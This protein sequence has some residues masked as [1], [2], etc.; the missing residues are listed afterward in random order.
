[1]GPGCGDGWRYAGD[2]R[3]GRAGWVRAGTGTRRSRHSRTIWARGRPRSRLGGAG[4]DSACLRC[5]IVREQHAYVW[6]GYGVWSQLWAAWALPFAWA[7]SWR[8]MTDKRFLAPAAA[9]VALTA[10]LHF[11]TGYLAFA[12]VVIFPWLVRRDLR[13][14]VARAAALLVTS[15]LASAWVWLPLLLY[16]RWAAINQVLAGTP[17]QNGYGAR[18]DLA[19]LVTGRAFDNGHLPVISLLVA[20]GL[21]AVLARWGDA[22]EGRAFV[23][24]F[25]TA[26]LLSFGRTTFG[27]LVSVIPGSMDVFFRRFFMG[28]QLA[29]ICGTGSRGRQRCS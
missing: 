13:H 19:W 25:G 5:A 3:A 16:A 11:E 29:G 12:A 21:L 15:L 20:A 24:L 27:G 26:L 14:R 10:A 6:T 18:Q 9:L 7:L 2:R 8:A 4:L 1:M 28:S 17:L 23:V 22:R